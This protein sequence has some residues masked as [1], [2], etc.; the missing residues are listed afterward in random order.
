MVSS[1]VESLRQQCLALAAI[2]PRV[3]PW[4]EC[5]WYMRR[6]R[7][8]Y[9]PF[10]GLLLEN[11]ER[12]VMVITSSYHKKLPSSRRFCGKKQS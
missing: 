1:S 8:F 6:D 11:V 9:V 10:Q 12:Q 2:H 7:N 4:N 5:V 3:I